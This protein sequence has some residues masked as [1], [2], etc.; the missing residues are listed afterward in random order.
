M[1]N[2]TRRLGG[3]ALAAMMFAAACSSAGA[4][5]T[6]ATTTAA[7]PAQ[8]VAASTD[9]AATPAASTPAAAAP[10]TYR[11]TK[12]DGQLNG[13]GATFPYPLYSKWGA[14]YNTKCGVKLNYQ[15]IGS[16]GGVKGWQ[17]NTVDFGAS[18]AYLQDSEIATAAKNGEPV[19]I[20]VAFGAVVVAY[21]LKG[22]TAPLKMT[23]DIIAGIFDGKI[24]KWNDPAIAAANPGITLPATDISVVHRSDGSG[25]TS[26]F[27]T[28]LTLTSPDW[29]TTVGK[30]DK[31]KSAGKTVTWPVGLGA[32][33][34]EGVTQ[35]INQ[36]DGGVGYIELQ[37]AL[38][39]KIPFADVQ[40]SSGSWITPSLAS[41]VAAANLSSYP[42]DLR[43]N[44]ANS[45]VATGY[46]ISGSTWLIVYKDLS[47]VMKN[48]D[49]AN[50]LVDYLWWAI[51]E[52]Q[53]ENASLNYASIPA[54][55]LPL[56]EAAV[57]SINWAGT[58]LLP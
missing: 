49:R 8:T 19:E 9:T 57:K 52:G 38:S 16:G 28:Y 54:N 26:I 35:G 10:M 1:I 45:P 36:T 7:T 47:K 32:S 30:G 33:G 44:L 13:A 50:A 37:Y 48:Q 39:N 53:N 20:P 41:V 14:D 40:N 42:A 51:H 4:S 12:G 29:V 18:D 25:T 15:S 5:P 17:Q 6:P 55:L 11:C 21:N 22:L 3:L 27:T 34:N 24:T 31:T 43:F 23:A 56:D 2:G 46:P 58:P